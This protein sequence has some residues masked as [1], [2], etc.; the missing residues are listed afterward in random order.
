M[1]RV[2]RA[3]PV[4]DGS[5]EYLER[6]LQELQTTRARETGAFYRKYGVARESAFLQHTAHGALLIVVTE[7]DAADAA[8]STY[9]GSQEK[10]EAWFKDSVREFSGV[11]LNAEP[12]G[13]L[14]R[15]IFDWTPEENRGESPAVER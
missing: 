6:F 13:P 10:F 9:G 5:K 11:D 8:F 1:E 2:V 3:F 15:C 7:L 12:R 14:A 4:R